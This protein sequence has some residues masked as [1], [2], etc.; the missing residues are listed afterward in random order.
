MQIN[1]NGVV[2]FDEPVRQFTPDSFPLESSPIVAPFWA[3]VDT[4]RNDGRV[5]FRQSVNPTLLSRASTDV[6]T[7]AA[8]FD[9]FQ[10]TWLLIV[11][12]DNVTY[13]GGDDTTGV[14]QYS[15]VV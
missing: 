15:N 14:S 10:A 8:G 11:T 1:T 3:D 4:T 7:H 13:F 5:H 2:S 9:T 6:R 12:W